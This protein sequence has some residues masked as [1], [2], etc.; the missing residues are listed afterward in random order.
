M[1]I[2]YQVIE[3]SEAE[4]ER[5]AKVERR[6][7]RWMMIGG[8]RRATSGDWRVEPTVIRKW[9]PHPPCLKDLATCQ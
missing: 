8:R 7:W 9:S 2:C 4:R 5:E 1:F 6:F 3:S